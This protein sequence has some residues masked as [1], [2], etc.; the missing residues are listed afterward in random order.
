MIKIFEYAMFYMPSPG[1]I[2]RNRLEVAKRLDPRKFKVSAFANTTD[3]P[4]HIAP[5]R[6]SNKLN[7][8]AKILSF[9]PDIIHTRT[10]PRCLIMRYLIKVRE[11]KSKHVLTLHGMPE[12]NWLWG[13]KLAE[14]ADIVTCVSRNTANLA[15]REYGVDSIVIYNG[16]DTSFFAPKE[17]HNERPQILFVGRYV[18]FKGSDLVVQLAKYFPECDFVM[19]GRGES[20]SLVAN[21]A[22]LKNVKVNAPVPHEK[23]TS[24]YANSDILL[25]PSVREGFSNVILEALACGLPIVCFDTSS[26][27]EAVEHDKSGLLSNSLSEMKEH[28]EYLIGD[29]EAR[30]EFS[31]NARKRAL[32]FDWNLI[33]PQW[34][35]LFEQVV[36]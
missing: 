14:D 19:Y 27:R 26:F 9:N 25:F 7:A 29:E 22:K 1:T 4:S 20:S 34:S 2:D 35:K 28:L 16:I 8:V 32:E 33:A 15:K 31:G 6:S 17:H 10:W 36:T 23:M 30:R 5:I 24:V 12:E 21:A 13:K 3:F 11:R 18:G